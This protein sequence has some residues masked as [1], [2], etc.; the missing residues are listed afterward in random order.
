[1]NTIKQS[2]LKNPQDVKGFFIR[3]GYFLGANF[4]Y[5]LALDLFFLP[6]QIAAGGFAGIATVLCSFLPFQVGVMALLMT[7]PLLVW[8]LKV[9]GWRYTGACFLSAL[10]YMVMV[11]G[12]STL[13]PAT[14]D[15]LMASIL[16]GALYA[17]GAVFILKA[18]TSAGGTDLLARLLLTKFPTMSLGKL[19]IL[20]DGFS[21]VFAICV[22]GELEYGLYAAIAVYT[23]GLLTDRFTAGFDLAKL[24]FI[25]TNDRHE[26]IAQTIMAQMKRGVT[27]QN[28]EGMYGKTAKQVLMVVIRPKEV[29]RL[30]AIVREVD[31]TAFVVIAQASEVQGGGFQESKGYYNTA[32]NK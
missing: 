15:P 27:H 4:M 20:V 28:G 23:C 22:F 9:K 31:P 6:H 17:V 19:F 13:E 11:D 8:S 1:M 25:I 2:I 14:S 30:K 32:I 7:L 3:V 21:V 29:Y 10:V 24:C 26:E 18:D 16:G 12:L 5:A